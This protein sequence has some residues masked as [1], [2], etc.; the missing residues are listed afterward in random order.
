MCEGGSDVAQYRRIRQV[1]LP[2]RNGKLVRNVGQQR[3]GDAEI[4]LGVLEIDGVDLVR[5]GGR[6]RLPGDGAL[7][8][9]ID[10][11]VS[12]CI[13]IEIE[14][15]LVEA[16]ERVEQ[17]GD[18]VV[19]LDLRGQRVG[20]EAQPADKGAAHRR[21][22]DLWIG[23]NM[24]IEIA[25][26]AV[27]LAAQDNL[28]DRTARPGQP[29]GVH[30]QFLGQ[31]GRRGRLPVGSCQHGQAAGFL[32]QHIDRFDDP[33]H[34][35]E[36]HLTPGAQHQPVGEIVDVLGGAGEMDKLD[37]GSE[38]ADRRYPLLDEVLDCLDIVIGS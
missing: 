2:A 38:P 14:Q 4:A 5:H 31:G 17:F 12:P 26:G 8:E 16:H 28:R 33:L 21:P 24:G 15:H 34:V 11:D 1:P 32:G 36:Q 10:G 20:I 25:H 19:R 30:A 13:T 27:D 18:V 6:A 29:L 23:R 35:L 9:I 22:V 7:A 3:V 37:A